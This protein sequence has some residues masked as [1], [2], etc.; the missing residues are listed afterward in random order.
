MYVSVGFNYILFDYNVSSSSATVSI[1]FAPPADSCQ[2]FNLG[3]RRSRPL[4]LMRLL[5]PPLANEAQ[6][7]VNFDALL[8][9][10]FCSPSDVFLVSDSVSFS[11]SELGV[12]CIALAIIETVASSLT[13]ANGQKGKKF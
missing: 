12:F 4:K 3:P 7:S 5:L 13:Q 8:S 6:I 11:L 1:A 10:F 9:I 2:W